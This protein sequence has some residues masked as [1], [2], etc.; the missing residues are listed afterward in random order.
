VQESN[1]SEHA[2]HAHTPPGPPPSSWGLI[3]PQ[4][5]ILAVIDDCAESDRAAQALE[6]AGIP[7]DDIFLIAGGFGL[8]FR[9]NG[10]LANLS[11]GVAPSAR[12][13]NRT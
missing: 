5:D 6:A 2:G 9:R 8:L 10:S 4:G 13:Q 3:Y 11:E 7:A 1:A 12:L